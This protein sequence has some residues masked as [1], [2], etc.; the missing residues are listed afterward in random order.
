MTTS[1]KCCNSNSFNFI[2]YI[3]SI[4]NAYNNGIPVN[5]YIPATNST[6]TISFEDTPNNYKG[7][8]NYN[9]AINYARKICLIYLSKI[10]LVTIPQLNCQVPCTSLKSVN[11]ISQYMNSENLSVYS[12]NLSST[13]D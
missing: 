8:K 5:I 2:T 1:C 10:R 13:T 6:L 7:I 11:L 12:S 9:D 4:I 3:P